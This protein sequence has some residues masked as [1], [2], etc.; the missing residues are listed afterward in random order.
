MDEAIEHIRR[1]GSNHTEIILTNDYA[2]SQEWLRRVNSS[3][4]GVNCST[5]FSDGFQL[6]L[7]A[8]IGI[9]TSKLHAY[10]PMGLEGL[11]TR[12]FVLDGGRSAAR[13]SRS[14]RAPRIGLFGG[15]FNPIHLGHLRAAEEVREAL[16]L[17][18]VALH[19]ERRFRPTSDERARIRSR[20]RR[21]DS[22]GS[23][24]RSPATRPS[25]WIGSRSI[26]RAPRTSSTR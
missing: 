19:P 10:G 1:Y 23:R 26:A 4:V 7:G 13:M 20:P 22:S 24:A 21:D 18:R 25:T 9:S 16:D 6:G 2:N 12:K 11:T 17:D 5:G 14:P 8:E 3:T 15:T